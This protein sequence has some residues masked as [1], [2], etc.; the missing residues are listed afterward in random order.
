MAMAQGWLDGWRDAW[1]LALCAALGLLALTAELRRRA[2]RRRRSRLEKREAVLKMALDTAATAILALDAEGRIE[3]SNEAARRMLGL[4]AG[5]APW[6][7]G[8]TFRPPQEGAVDAGPLDALRRGRRLRGAEYLLRTDPQSEEM[9]V[10]VTAEPAPIGALIGAVMTL[11]DVTE[12]HRARLLGDRADRLDAL[13]KLT[14]GVAHDF[15]NLLSTILGA[16]QLAQRRSGDDP[17]IARHLDAALRATRTGAELVSRLLGFAKRDSVQIEEIAVA[18]LLDEIAPLAQNLVDASISLRFAR[19]DPGLSVRCD[20]AQMIT[21]AL[22]LVANSR[23]AISAAR[24]QGSIRV[25]AEVA[26]DDPGLVEIRVIDDGPG[27]SAEIYARALD[28]FF[29]TKGPARGT[30]LG[31]SMVYGAVRR[32]G[33]QLRIDTEQGS[34]ATVRMRLRRGAPADPRAVVVEP[35]RPDGAGR[36]VLLVE[37]ELDL[38]ETAEAMLHDLGYAPIRAADAAQAL[39]EIES[40]RVIDAMITDVMMPGGMSGPELADAARATRPELPVIFV[41]GYVAA[42]VVGA[43]R[44]GARLLR[45][46]YAIE[47]LAQALRAALR[48]ARRTGRAEQPSVAAR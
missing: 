6:P 3:L 39:R 26:T 16:L 31:L 30:G 12:Q 11:E 2:E 15:N 17:R 38:L 36:A 29:T 44:I 20:R 18:A 10:R 37:D 47:E 45:K 28:P 13:G 48:D 40:G 24:G 35:L 1:P 4:P 14:G 25:E 27:M 23:D 21:A 34:G 32:C 7:E 43:E 5:P 41:S 42:S 33:G 19:P 9:R 8:A 46:P 22:N